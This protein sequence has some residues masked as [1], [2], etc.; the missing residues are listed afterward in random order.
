MCE[1]SASA[2]EKKAV[3]SPSAGRGMI[4]LLTKS[5]TCEAALAPASTA[6]RTLPTS[7]QPDETDVDEV[8][9]PTASGPADEPDADEVADGGDSQ[10]DS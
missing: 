10:T 1:R 6:A 3:A 4:W 7:D 2:Y 5:P 8:S 9:E